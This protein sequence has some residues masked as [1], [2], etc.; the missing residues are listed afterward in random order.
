MGDGT[1]DAVSGSQGADREG[2]PQGLYPQGTGGSG[3]GPI[4]AAGTGVSQP[5]AREYIAIIGAL[6]HMM[7]GAVT[8]H[9]TELNAAL[10]YEVEMSKMIDPYMLKLEVR[11]K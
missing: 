11:T 4:S 10:D 2:G 6:V 1:Q 8:L 7:G 3:S 9:S 5:Q